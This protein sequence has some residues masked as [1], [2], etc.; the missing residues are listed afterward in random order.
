MEFT[1]KGTLQ[2]SMIAYLKKVI[3][4]FPEMITGK[5]AT[6]GLDHLF[7]IRD[8]KEARLLDKKR[9]TAFHHTIAQLL[10]MATQARRDIQTAVA[11]L[12]TRAKAPDEDDWGKLK[13]VLKY[14]NGMKHSK[15]MLSIE[16]LGLLK[17]Y[18]DG[19]HNVHWDC[20]GHGGA[21]FTM[22]RGST[23]SYSRKIKLNTMSSS[24]TELLVSHMYMP[25]MLWSLNFIQGQGYEAECVGLYQDNISSQLL[26]K[27]GRMSSGR[28]TKCIKSKFFFIKDRVDEGEIK[29]IDCLGEE[30]WADILTKPLQGMAFR[31]MRSK[32][33]NCPVNYD[34]EEEIE[35]DLTKQNQQPAKTGTKTTTK[36]VASMSLQEC[37]GHKQFKAI[38]KDRPVGVART[39]QRWR[40]ETSQPKRGNE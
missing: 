32:L 15:L 20:K 40:V 17:W 27:N 16:D 6:P 38:A 14:V 7:T 2:V 36:Q 4:S 5:V 1:S 26:I 12:T 22:G 19:S 13:R 3:A 29:V 11:F 30:M 34:K 37:V 25:E 28:K 23:S 35:K 31:K 10:F 24:E 9:G 8:K 18:V 33:M 39:K 21:M